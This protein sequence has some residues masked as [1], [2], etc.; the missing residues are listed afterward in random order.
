MEMRQEIE[1]QGVGVRNF[2]SFE[3]FY[4]PIKPGK[5]L[6]MGQVLGSPTE[7]SNGSGKSSLFEPIP[8]TW[9]KYTLRDKNPSRDQKGECLTWVDF[10]KN[11]DSFKT[12]RYL[13]HSKFG[14]KV[15]I[16]QNDE[17]LTARKQGSTEEELRKL[18]SLSPEILTSTMIVLQGIPQNFTQM[19]PTVRKSMIE[20]YLGFSVW[21]QFRPRFSGH[22]KN[23]NLT[24]A[25][26]ADDYLHA[27]RKLNEITQKYQ[28]QQS[29]EGTNRDA[30]GAEIRRLTEE[31][32]FHNE[33]LHELWGSRLALSE[34]SLSDLSQEHTQLLETL[35]FLNH[36]LK[37]LES[38][39]QTKVCGQ[40]GQDYPKDQI[41]AALEELKFIQEKLKFIQ[42]K[43]ERQNILINK[44]KNLERQISDERNS[45]NF[46]LQKIHGLNE[47]INSKPSQS[48]DDLLSAMHERDSEYQQI[49]AKMSEL[50]Q[51]IEHVKYLDNLLL[52][53]SLFRTKVLENY[54]DYIN[55]LM[56]TVCPLIFNDLSVKL[57]IEE[58]NNGIEFEIHK[59]D[60]K[61]SYPSLSGGE[62]RK[63]DLICILAFQKFVMEN[64]GISSNLLVFDEVFDHIDSKG[65][66][67]VLSSLDV[68]FPE[69]SSIY[70]ISHNNHL[71]S[72]FSSV[73]NV[74]K[75]KDISV[76][77]LSKYAQGM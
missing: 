44:S 59:K 39:S 64:S 74:V 47:K 11:G 37:V 23:L 5:H 41:E 22:L 56:D 14:N 18:M 72:R 15:K 53:S 2:Q 35:A 43:L 26:I 28:V 17:D 31:I 21:T 50:D 48:L 58:K 29:I 36:K 75:D 40:C 32:Y 9:F 13:G 16:Y 65:I 52:P 20:E 70:I 68:F 25:A 51:S 42:D 77:D 19:S 34:K 12:E 55:S 1:V 33:V 10:R 71:K 62:K 73:I 54:L 60:V 67:S 61:K 63:L 66:D 69:T 27:Q 24:R 38:V 3:E 49:L 57:I 76:L 46:K 4:L 7:E 30:L 45:K 6:V 8:W